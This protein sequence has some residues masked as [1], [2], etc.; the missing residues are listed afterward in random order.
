MWYLQK[1][2]AL[3]RELLFCDTASLCQ[4]YEAYQVN[5][6]QT[7]KYLTFLNMLWSRK[8]KTGKTAVVWFFFLVIFQPQT[9]HLWSYWKSQLWYKR[10]FLLKILSQLRWAGVVCGFLKESVA[11]AMQH[12]WGG[13][14][15]CMSQGSSYAMGLC[16][17][18]FLT[19][20]F[21][22]YFI[23]VTE[24]KHSYLIK[25]IMRILN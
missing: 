9:K 24:I 12:E 20:F 11:R 10:M 14:L 15:V 7:G 2:V 16:A 8:I 22:F 6:P 17:R 18:I 21:S 1:H 3:S 13:N 5:L 23:A 25:V 19:L 4:L